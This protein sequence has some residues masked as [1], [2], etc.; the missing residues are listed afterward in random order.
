MHHVMFD[1]DG[2]LVESFK[3]D[4]ECY[5][6]AV[7]QVLGHGID[8]RWANYT[9]VTDT[10][11]LDQHLHTHNLIHVREEIH[12]QVKSTFITNIKEHLFRFPAQEVPGAAKFL[13]FI[14][15]QGNV[16]VSIATGGWSETACLKL[17]SAGVDVAGIP[18]ASANDHYSRTEI[19][20]LALQK[21][22][23]PPNHKLTYFGDA[24]WDKKACKELNFNFVLVG[25][26]VVHGQTISD[27]T[28]IKNAIRYIGL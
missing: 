4:E 10:G 9:H 2:T 20:K 16:S 5:I 27:F 24:A 11:I 6:D 17:A 14:R 18:M 25:D 12:A 22:A 8:S 15:K 23:V 28:E 21:A 19:M 7:S 26:Q 1:V 3:F 13:S